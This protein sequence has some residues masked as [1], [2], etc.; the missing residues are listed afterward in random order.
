MRICRCA[1]TGVS[2]NPV[3]TSLAARRPNARAGKGG[4]PLIRTPRTLPRVLSPAEIDALRAA[5]RTYRDRAVV[6]AMVLGGLRLAPDHGRDRV[7]GG[8]CGARPR[9]SFS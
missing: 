1:D 6:D 7:L 9:P 8:E 2:R 3:P 4:A 5:L